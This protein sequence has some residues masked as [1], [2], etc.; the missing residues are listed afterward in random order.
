MLKCIFVLNGL[1]KFH[2][3][4]YRHC[5][6]INKS[7]RLFLFMFTLYIIFFCT[8]HVEVSPKNYLRSVKSYYFSLLATS[9]SIWQHVYITSH[10][11]QS[12]YSP[13]ISSSLFVVLHIRPTPSDL[14]S[15][16]WACNKTR[17]GKKL[18]FVEKNIFRFLGFWFFLGFNVRRTDTKSWPRHSRRSSHKSY[19]IHPFPCHIPHHL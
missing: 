11:I 1:V 5:W 6:K 15:V 13:V 16:N 14:I 9:L 4:I 8:L 12:F 3:K 19:V 10:S 7:H 18:G 17:A 2:R